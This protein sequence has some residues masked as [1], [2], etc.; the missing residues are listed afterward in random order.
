MDAEAIKRKSFGFDAAMR[1]IPEISGK[2]RN[3]IKP[4]DLKRCYD[5][6]S[7]D[8]SVVG[9]YDYFVNGDISSLKNNLYVS[10]VLKLTSLAISEDRFE[11]Q[12]PDYLLHSMM[13]DSNAWSRRSRS[14]HLRGS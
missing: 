4:I 7:R 10:C 5:G 8:H 3:R 1:H 13:S 2:I 11:L 6:L 9:L 12:T 14:P